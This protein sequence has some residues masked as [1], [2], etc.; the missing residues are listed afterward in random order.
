MATSKEY[1]D[2]I[3]DQSGLEGEI[4]T[5]QMMGEYLLYYMGKHIGGLYDNRMLVMSSSRR[6]ALD[7]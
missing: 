1:R 7:F 6:Q 3:I 2:F 4:I 5:R